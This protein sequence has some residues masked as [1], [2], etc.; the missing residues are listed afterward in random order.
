MLVANWF[1]YMLA[2]TGWLALSIALLWA[3]E[4]LVYYIRY[5]SRLPTAKELEL[6]YERTAFESELRTQKALLEEERS[7][8]NR[9]ETELRKTLEQLVSKL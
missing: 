9:L 5:R 3:G 7:R 8:N 2:F 1:M 6:K 4:Q